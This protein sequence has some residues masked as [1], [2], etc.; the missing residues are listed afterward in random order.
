MSAAVALQNITP[1]NGSQRD[2]N[3]ATDPEYIRLRGLAEAAHERRKQYSQDSQNAYKSGDHKKAK[4]FSEKSKEQNKIAEGYNLQAAEYAF[5]TNNA[6]SE[7]DEIDLH[8]LF[9]KEVQWILQ[10]RIALAV[11]NHEQYLK[12]VVGKGLHSKNGISK[13]RPAVEELCQQ[14]NLRNYYDNKNA[15]VLIIELTNARIPTDWGSTDYVTFASKSSYK[16]QSNNYSHQNQPQYQQQHQQY[17]NNNNN[18]NGGLL[19]MVL[20]L[21]C[22]CLQK[23]I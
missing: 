13:I 4:E 20:Q 19:S 12:V 5:A 7:S 10:K 3:H 9:V 11:R 16:T 18:N 21:F 6:D 15:G 22:S 8:G 14:G 2:Y 23:N 1:H 17:N